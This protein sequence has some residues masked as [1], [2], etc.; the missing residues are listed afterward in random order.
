MS[1]DNKKKL[2]SLRKK[3]DIID[4]QLLKIIKKRSEVIKK[5]ITIKVYKKEI[6][7]KK[8]INLILK[9]IKKES[10]KKNIDPKITQRIWKNMI[11]SYINF[12]KRNFKKK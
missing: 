10:I 2:N 7:D 5:V 3:L 8:R 6:V 1:P 11:W 9:R 4:N 12:E